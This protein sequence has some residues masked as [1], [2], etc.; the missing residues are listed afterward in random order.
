VTQLGLIEGFYGRPWEQASRL[1][2]INWCARLGFDAYLYAPKAD[3]WL[4]RRW[5][6]AWPAGELTLLRELAEQGAGNGLEVAVG[7]SPFALYRDYTDAARNTLRERVLGIRDS[8]I[9]SLALLFDDMPGDMA[10]LAA[11]QAEIASDVQHWGQW[12]HLRVCPTYYSDD[13]ILDRV[14]GT[15]PA[16]YLKE[17]ASQLDD[18]VA[19]FWTGPAVCSESIS[20]NHIER[21]REAIGRPVALWDNYP[22]NDSKLR[23]GH[24][25]LAPL[26]HRE[27]GLRTELE[28]HWCNAM[29]QAA[30]SLPALASLVELYGRQGEEREAVL[31]EAGI[32]DALLAACLSMADTSLDELSSK[33]RASLLDLA[34][35]SSTA[36]EELGQWLDGRYRFDPTCLTD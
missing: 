34:T 15:R 19:V 7:L 29:N 23:S 26:Q 18:S 24:L 36:A 17:L 35:V 28:S 16:N 30:L 25:Y 11:R 8:G 14:F 33:Q 3:P 6:E 2:M 10:G 9:E 13:E 22:V 12:R 32:S 31:S 21:V 5:N 27:A 1:R 20:T 4:R